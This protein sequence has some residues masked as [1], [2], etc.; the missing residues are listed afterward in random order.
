ME[1][2]RRFGE[3][4]LRGLGEFTTLKTMSYDYDSVHKLIN[5]LLNLETKIINKI[6]E[7]KLATLMKRKKKKRPKQQILIPTEATMF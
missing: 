6:N 2:E 1:Y 5:Y 3:Y 7:R 4:F